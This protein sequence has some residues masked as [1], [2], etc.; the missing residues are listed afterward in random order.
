MRKILMSN[1]GETKTSVGLGLL[2]LICIIVFVKRYLA[3]M[4]IG[5]PHAWIRV[6]ITS[7]FWWIGITL[8]LIVLFIIFS[9]I[10]VLTKK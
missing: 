9:A 2:P 7:F 4:N 1:S 8:V 5:D 10:F 6:F 3:G